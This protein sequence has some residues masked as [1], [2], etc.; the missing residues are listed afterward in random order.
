MA[1]CATDLPGEP[2]LGHQGGSGD[3]LDGDRLRQ[4]G[5]EAAGFAGLGQSGNEP[6][7]IS[8]SR[9]RHCTDGGKLGLVASPMRP[10]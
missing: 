10:A 1:C 7:D 6:R 2:G 8:R 3:G 5:G 4:A 9:S